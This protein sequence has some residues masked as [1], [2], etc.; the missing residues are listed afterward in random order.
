[1]HEF[2]I[3]KIELIIESIASIENYLQEINTSEDF[4]ISLSGKKSLDAVMMRL[5][6]IGENIKKINKTDIDLFESNLQFDTN[7]IIR[8]RDFISHHYEKLDSDIVFEICQI[9]IPL[10][11]QKIQTFLS[12]KK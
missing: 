12:S 7:N 6:S 3:D 10:L 4:K 1:M 2:I 11:K 9:D 5:Q 8:F